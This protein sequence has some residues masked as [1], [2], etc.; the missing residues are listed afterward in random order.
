MPKLTPQPP[1]ESALYLQ[2]KC[3]VVYSKQTYLLG[4]TVVVA[5]SY[6]VCLALL[7]AVWVLQTR[8]SDMR[9]RIIV[10]DSS[11]TLM[12]DI[13]LAHNGERLR[14]LLLQASM[15]WRQKDV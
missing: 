1:R 14:S 4:C 6:S 13:L 12:C 3:K 8:R 2:D 15:G 10:H 7:R 5:T 11:A 9:S